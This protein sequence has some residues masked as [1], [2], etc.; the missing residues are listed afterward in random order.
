MVV[1][2]HV[3]HATRKILRYELTQLGTKSRNNEPSSKFRNARHVHEHVS[4]R[5]GKVGTS[6]Y[7]FTT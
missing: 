6:T 2:I 3:G 7:G 1:F 4:N 5:N